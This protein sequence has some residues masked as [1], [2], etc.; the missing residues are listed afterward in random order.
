MTQVG[1]VSSTGGSLEFDCL[2]FVT[3]RTLKSRESS[4]LKITLTLKNKSIVHQN[5]L[6]V[7]LQNLFMENF[8]QKTGGTDKKHFGLCIGLDSLYRTLEK[9]RKQV[10]KL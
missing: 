2:H 4:Y 1:K 10:F 8:L 3:A 5:S 6:V 9:L 7:H